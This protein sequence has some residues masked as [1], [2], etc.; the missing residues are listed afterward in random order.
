MGRKERIIGRLIHN[1][2]FYKTEDGRQLYELSIGE[3]LKLLE[4]QKNVK[5]T[6]NYRCRARNEI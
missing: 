2:K 1:Y 4:A 5:T 6:Q 3:L